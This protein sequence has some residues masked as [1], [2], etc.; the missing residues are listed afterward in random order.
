MMLDEPY[1]VKKQE[2]SK[3]TRKNL[4]STYKKGLS[5]RKGVEKDLPIME[6]LFKDTATRKDFFYRKL[7]Y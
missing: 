1:D 7:D 3:S 5:V 2:F 6:D 4:E